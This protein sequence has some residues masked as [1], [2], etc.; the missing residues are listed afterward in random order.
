M[1]TTADFEEIRRTLDM[2]K[3]ALAR[4]FPPADDASRLIE[5]A[6]RLA[7][8]AEAEVAPA[9]LIAVVEFVLAGE[10]Y[11]LE[12]TQVREVCAL[13]DFTPVPCTPAFV[14]GII[15]LRGEIH[16]IIDLKR[17][18]DLPES[19]ITDLNKVLIIDGDGMRLGILADTI[20]GVRTVLRADVRPPP[21]TLTEVR[22]D[23]LLG[24][25]GERLIVLDATKFPGDARI[26]V[27]EHVRHA[28]LR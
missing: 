10:H 2:A 24:I 1:K 17:F 22:A 5:R 26:V 8:E 18:F 23:Y 11:A 4:G 21:P 7:G 12:L 13:K 28:D 20:L 19:G 14:L 15:N 27:N 9:D 16:T 6:H 25:T 3:A